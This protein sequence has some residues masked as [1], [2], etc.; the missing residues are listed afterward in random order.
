M[1]QDNVSECDYAYQYMIKNLKP[2]YPSRSILP[3]SG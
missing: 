1:S 2:N 3:V